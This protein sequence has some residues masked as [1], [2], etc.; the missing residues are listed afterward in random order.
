MAEEIE[1][2]A[3]KHRKAGAPY[4]RNYVSAVIKEALGKQKEIDQEEREQLERANRRDALEAR[5]GSMLIHLRT[6]TKD[7]IDIRDML[8]EDPK[9]RNTPKVGALASKKQDFMATLQSMWKAMGV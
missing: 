3:K 9:L 8:D 6:A 5:I 1:K 4:I 7:A 2:L